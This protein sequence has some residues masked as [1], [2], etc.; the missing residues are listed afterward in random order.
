[1]YLQ[2]IFSDIA[3]SNSALENLWKY[4]LNFWKYTTARRTAV[5]ETWVSRHYGGP[6]ENPLKTL[7]TIQLECSM[8]FQ[9]APN[10][11]KR[12]RSLG[13]MVY[14]FLVWLYL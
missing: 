8:G 2:I 1:M 14:T 12:R 11:S 3:M 6:I 13:Q 7:N 4:E 5:Q 10:L 9:G